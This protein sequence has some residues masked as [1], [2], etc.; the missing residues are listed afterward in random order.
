MCP[1]TSA[2]S[3][4]RW[5]AIAARTFARTVAALSVSTG[6]KLELEYA[7]QERT[8]A[9][10]VEELVKRATRQVF[11]ALLPM[12]G[13]ASVIEAFE[14]GWKV[15]VSAAM[16]SDEYLEGLDAIAGLREA[17]AALAG[18]DSAPRLASAI[19]F[20]LEGLHLANRLNKDVSDAGSAR[21]ARR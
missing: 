17:A 11:D 1:T 6:G 4:G 16:P 10:V 21:Y 20:V 2:S 12:E 14:Q 15:E 5:G 8:P 19:E 3:A 9:E 13:I 7:G 18:G